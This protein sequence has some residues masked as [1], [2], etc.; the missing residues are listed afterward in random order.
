M[1]P[2]SNETFYPMEVR[3]ESTAKRSGRK[4]TKWEWMGWYSIP[5]LSNDN[6][7]FLKG[8][9]LEYFEGDSLVRYDLSS[10]VKY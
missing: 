2:K 5:N 7:V 6:T 8:K 10:G 4:Y 1:L 3:Y 9:Y